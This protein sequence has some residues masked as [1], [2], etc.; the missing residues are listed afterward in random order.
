MKNSYRLTVIEAIL[1]DSMH[2]CQLKPYFY[3][4]ELNSR[5]VN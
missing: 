1:L 2:H 3:K 4:E 5:N